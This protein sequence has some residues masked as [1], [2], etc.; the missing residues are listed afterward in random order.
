LLEL[1]MVKVNHCS[2]ASTRFELLHAEWVFNQLE[3]YLIRY[4]GLPTTIL[5]LF[6]M[7]F[8]IKCLFLIRKS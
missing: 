1:L 6:L 7:I 8:C 3:N 2:V 5:K 4:G